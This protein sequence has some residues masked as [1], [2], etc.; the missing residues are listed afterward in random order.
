MAPGLKAVLVYEGSSTDDILNRMATDNLAKQ[1]GASWTYPIDAGS[2]QAFFKW[3]RR[4]SRSSMP[5]GDSD[6]YPGAV[7]T[8]A[9]DP[10]ITVVGGTTLTT[11]GPGGAWSAE[12]VWNWGGGIG[13]SGGI[14]TRNAIPILAAGHQHVGQRR[15]DHHAQH[16]RRGA[17]GGQCL[18]YLRQ[19]QCGRFWRHQL[20]HAVV[21]GFVALANQLARQ[22][23]RARPP[24]ASSTRA[25]YAIGKGQ[26]SYASLF[27]DITTGNNEIPPAQPILRPCRAMILHRLGHAHGSKSADRAGLCNIPTARCQSNEW[28]HGGGPGGRPVCSRRIWFFRSS[29]TEPAV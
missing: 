21:G 18:C 17:D 10:N 14:S 4:D 3:P 9:D 22:Q 28:L 2:E 11:T 23:R 7:S 16:S 5:L 6:A 19:R 26:S 13:S 15:L 24:L 12:T 25:V 29:I 20:R 27:H 8:P 1:I